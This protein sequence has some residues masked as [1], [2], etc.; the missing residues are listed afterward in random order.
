MTSHSRAPALVAALLLGLVGAI[1]GWLPGTPVTPLAAQAI[2]GTVVDP[3]EGD[4]LSNVHL[5]LLG[6]G[7]RESAAVFSDDSGRFLLTAPAPG[8]WRIAADLLGYG[9]VR[10]E[11]LDLRAGDTLT[12]EVRMAVAPVEIEEPVV[13]RGRPSIMSLDITEFERRRRWGERSGLGHFIYGEEID[14]GRPGR[15]TDLLRRV[16]GVTV[17]G[18]SGYGQI[19]QMRGGCV[20]AIFIDGGQINSGGQSGRFGGMAS[21]DTYVDVASIE[22]IEVYR[23]AHQP[24]GRFVDRSGCG[25]VLVWTRR[26]EYDP[27]ARFS[28]IRLLVGL[29]LV[30]SLLLLR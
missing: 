21:L 20:P 10:S 2:S 22:G 15:P 28:W 26:G 25:L 14:R 23:G 27:E 18:T 19:V 9:T 11:P 17:S 5:R 3:E 13:V 8:W 4:P 24:G 29:G 1:A 12:V 16:P 30:A 6:T 7:D